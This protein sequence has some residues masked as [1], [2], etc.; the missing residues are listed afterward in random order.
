M[1]D[2]L[3]QAC[4]YG[5]TSSSLLE[6][7]QG[8][9]LRMNCVDDSESTSDSYRASSGTKRVSDCALSASEDDIRP[10]NVSDRI[11][12]SSA[13]NSERSPSETN[14][15]DD[16][17]EANND[18]ASSH[19]DAASAAEHPAAVGP[20]SKF[21]LQDTFHKH[22]R[23]YSLRL[24]FLLFLL[25]LQGSIIASVEALYR[26]SSNYVGVLS[27]TSHDSIAKTFTWA[28]L[29]VAIALVIALCWATVDM[30]VAR[31]DAFRRLS[32][33]EGAPSEVLFYDYQSKPF[34]APYRSCYRLWH[35]KTMASRCFAMLTFCSAVG[36]LVSFLVLPPL[37]AS[38]M[39]IQN[40][41]TP[42]DTMFIQMP[43]FTVEKPIVN[44]RIGELLTKSFYKYQGLPV[45]KSA[46]IS[47]MTA[48]L[49]M[50]P[51][52]GGMQ[53]ASWSGQSTGFVASF[54]CEQHDPSKLIYMDSTK[55]KRLSESRES[56]EKARID[57][58]QVQYPISAVF[59]G[60]GREGGCE[61]HVDM[62]LAEGNDPTGNQTD[63]WY[64]GGW[65][66]LSASNT[67]DTSCNEYLYLNIN[68]GS[69]VY[70]ESQNASSFDYVVVFESKPTFAA[71]V[72]QSS[73]YV[74]P[75]LDFTFLN[76][77][78]EPLVR[79]D[80]RKF[81]DMLTEIPSQTFNSTEF[82]EHLFVSLESAKINVSY[83]STDS[84]GRPTNIQ[85][86]F[87]PYSHY[88]ATKI[89]ET[90]HLYLE[91]ANMLEWANLYLQAAFVQRVDL[92]ADSWQTQ[93]VESVNLTA[94]SPSNRL[95]VD[96]GYTLALEA[97]LASLMLLTVAVFF[98]DWT[99]S[100]NLNF[101][102]GSIASKT[103]LVSVSTRF[104][105]LLRR[106]DLHFRPSTHGNLLRL[107]R[108]DDGQIRLDI[109]DPISEQQVVV[110]AKGKLVHP[111][112]QPL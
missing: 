74:A 91:T 46:W 64:Y 93:T 30:D 51:L 24:P 71:F 54:D 37:Q 26:F 67:T 34:T 62:P 15:V 97:V 23:P 57:F 63:E 4:P 21:S 29:P 12:R 85:T 32:S 107:F 48:I 82:E 20:L 112:A 99:G 59:T 76:D 27:I 55:A 52:G 106:Q 79:F 28:Y 39:S 47:D 42:I 16:I 45:A 89:P 22:W 11:A 40:V 68:H 33:I 58:E 7:A 109:L 73:Y 17:D 44:D 92:A 78:T 19:K 61:F 2:P 108:S 49:P 96:R 8:P 86:S 65:N 1:A 31:T 38:I 110:K 9:N 77:V 70:T 101:D 102:P 87:K 75:H 72:C 60:L 56:S 80:Q 35:S 36:H 69:L 98:L 53:D 103:S 14:V 6:S 88:F 5:G 104:L 18:Q 41:T 100:S 43:T 81:G 10:D 13:P 66:F 105:Q 3:P 90:L 83:P 84:F 50:M 25:M 94:Y 95:I 111:Q